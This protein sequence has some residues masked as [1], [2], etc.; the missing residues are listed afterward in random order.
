[1]KTVEY[2]VNGLAALVGLTFFGMTCVL[3]AQAFML[4]SGVWP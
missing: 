1:M 4:L 3:I 2:V